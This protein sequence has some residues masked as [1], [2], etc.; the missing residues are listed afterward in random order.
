MTLGASDLKMIQETNG[1]V[2]FFGI[3]WMVKRFASCFPSGLKTARMETAVLVASGEKPHVNLRAIVR[4]QLEAE[5][6]APAHIDDVRGCT[7]GDRDRF[8][9]FRRDGKV[10]G[11]LLSAIVVPASARAGATR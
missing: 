10:G 9:S 2:A 6:L 4:A 1:T 7:V 8:H 5:G 3:A 11:R